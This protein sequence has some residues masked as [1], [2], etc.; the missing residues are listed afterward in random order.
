MRSLAN[1]FFSCLLLI[2]TACTTTA[3]DSTATGDGGLGGATTTSSDGGSDA[4]GGGQGIGGSQLTGGGQG[5]DTGGDGNTGGTGGAGGDGT[6]TAASGAGGSGQ[7]GA[8]GI[9]A[10]ASA[11]GSGGSGQGGA[12]GIGTSASASGAGGSGQGGA[13][14]IGTSASASGAGG[15]G[16]GGA[17]GIGTSASA[18][19][20]GGSGQGGAG[21]IGTSVAASGAGG[22]GGSG[23]GGAGGIGTSVAA[24]G[25]GGA[26]GSGQGGAGGM[27]GG[28]GTGGSSG[29]PSGTAFAVHGAVGDDFT[30][31]GTFDAATYGF[32]LVAELP[33]IVS[34]G[35]ED[36]LDPDARTLSFTAA[37]SHASPGDRSYV[38]IDIDTGDV[39]A[40]PPFADG[41]NYPLHDPVTG[42][43]VA[44]RWDHA[45]MMEEFGIVDVMTATFT[46][47]STLPGILWISGPA[48]LDP[49]ARTYSFWSSSNHVTVDIDTG[50]MLT[51]T[52]V[53]Q[54]FINSH[55]DPVTGEVFALRF[56]AD[57][58]MTQL[59][60]VDVMT[61]TFTPFA[62]LVDVASVATFA[63]LN[64]V[65]RTY[66]FGRGATAGEPPGTRYMSVDIDTGL[67][68]S[69]A[70]ITDWYTS[71]L[72]LP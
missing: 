12:G 44:I 60:T 4:S 48:V 14:G 62:D 9:G 46:P 49:I 2:S 6:S 30:R 38:T 1:P 29:F 15:S 64:P 56:D 47:I 26:G 58:G 65:A 50:D 67:V 32:S 40:T 22:A 34:P 11:S 7:G 21:G 25:A 70:P 43:I 17:G 33:G 23:Q 72:A 24:S 16:Q 10:S 53:P 27:G 57:A 28:S 54:M 35:S 13:G 69:T 61:A 55:Y 66:S 45:A 3:C 39:L 31:F 52:P 71:V 18:S 59:G 63:L 41:F 68:V 36:V 8:G 5:G 37:L 20:A 51:V 42:N 19:G